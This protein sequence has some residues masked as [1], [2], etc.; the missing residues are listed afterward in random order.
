MLSPPLPPFSTL[1]SYRELLQ[2]SLMRAFRFT[3]LRL[4]FFLMLNQPLVADPVIETVFFELPQELLPESIPSPSAQLLAVPGYPNQADTLTLIARLYL[5]DPELHGPGPYPCVLILHGSGGLWSNDIIPANISPN[6][7]PVS[8]F[9]NWGDLL[10]AEGYACLFPDSFNP[11][12]IAGNFAGRRPHHDPSKDDALCSPN[13]ERPKDVIASLS[14]LQS[15]DDIDP[16]RIALMGFS[17]GAQTG[18]NALLDPSVNLGQYQ[19]N[20]I[21]LQEDGEGGMIEVNTSKEVPAPVRIPEG[22][23]L[24]KVCVF[25]YGGGGHYGYHGSPSSTAAGRYMLDRRTQAILF[26][27]SDDYLMGVSD[28]NTQPRPG[29]LYPIKQVLA[30]QAQADT[31]GIPNPIRHHYLLDRCNVHIPASERVT[32]SFD[33]GSNAIA[34]PEDWD[35]ANENPNQKA[36]RL[37]RQQVLRW[38]DY[39]LKDAPKLDIQRKSSNPHDLEVSWESNPRISYRLHKANATLQD[40]PPVTAWTPG[41]GARQQQLFPDEASAFFSLSYKASE[42]PTERIENEGFF[43]EYSDFDL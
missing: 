28:H 4:G 26:H 43:L 35:S 41:N 13:Y 23:P 27:G 16:K 19:V 37:A 6:N 22:L 5:P 39:G 8:Q 9:R 34:D 18:M 25:Y 21:D 40:W 3:L 31:L 10:V 11:R 38:L 30:S 15:R 36:R 42:A 17:H 14:Y 2:T 20:Y 24:P 1:A 29:T 33:S 12:G 7:A 32:H